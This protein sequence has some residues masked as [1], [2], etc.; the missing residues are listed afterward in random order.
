M[1]AGMPAAE[2]SSQSSG[3]VI[4]QVS[5]SN[6]G[7]SSRRTSAPTQVSSM[8][9]YPYFVFPWSVTL[10]RLAHIGALQELA[11]FVEP[12]RVDVRDLFGVIPAVARARH[13]GELL[14]ALQDVQARHLARGEADP[15]EDLVH[16]AI[17]VLEQGRA[18]GRRGAPG[19]ERVEHEPAGV[20]VNA[21]VVARAAVRRRVHRELKQIHRTCPARGGAG[22]AARGRRDGERGR[23][24]GAAHL[25]NEPLRAAAEQR[26][27]RAVRRAGDEDHVRADPVD[28]LGV[29]RDGADAGADRGGADAQARAAARDHPLEHLARLLQVAVYVRAHGAERRGVAAVAALDL[30]LGD[31]H[32]A[33]EAALGVADLLERA[34]T[35][36]PA[37]VGDGACAG[38]SAA[39]ADAG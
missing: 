33:L 26:A 8:Y 2:W 16:G 12:G 7:P 20:A 9:L 6:I 31:H 17:H 25:G 3:S 32:L 23:G 28:V 1:T 39:P 11:R 27:A 13:D 22:G 14:D 5:G 15:A 37:L 34:V 35:A 19:G 4:Q 38:A 24:A 30:A 10:A 36:P 21:V 29:A 18:G